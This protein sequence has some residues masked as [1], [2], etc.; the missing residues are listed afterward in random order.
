MENLKVYNDTIKKIRNKRFSMFPFASKENMMFEAKV[1]THK[2]A[3]ISYANILEQTTKLIQ[4]LGITD[5]LMASN[6]INFALKS[7]VFSKDGKYSYDKSVNSTDYNLDSNQNIDYCIPSMVVMSGKG[8]CLNANSFLNIIL[9]ELGYT[10]SKQVIGKGYSI[11]TTLPDKD[12]H[13]V[14]MINYKDDNLLY[15]ICNNEVFMIDKSLDNTSIS[16]KTKFNCFESLISEYN[17]TNLNQLYLLSSKL[18]TKKDPLETRKLVKESTSN[19][20]ALYTQNRKLLRSFQLS[21]NS[22]VETVDYELKRKVSKLETNRNYK[23]LVKEQKKATILYNA[24]RLK[25]YND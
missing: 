3:F 22:D 13:V 14:E 4:E 18:K 9:S 11:K 23:K 21:I 25:V 17:I 20:K 19:A 10:N 7:G 8:V 16:G 6:I 24:F 2:E 15:D 12:N 5:T 1:M